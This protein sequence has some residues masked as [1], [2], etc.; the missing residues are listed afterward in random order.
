MPGAS[1]GLFRDSTVESNI[2]LRSES[3]IGFTKE[4]WWE[5]AGNM[6]IKNRE[7]GDKDAE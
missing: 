3:I 4:A 5:G 7:E 1:I 6:E 2:C